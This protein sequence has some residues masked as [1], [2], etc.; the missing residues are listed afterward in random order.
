[1]SHVIESRVLES[2]TTTGA[3]DITL[4]GAVLGFRRFSAACAVGDTMPYFI[5]AIDSVGLPTGDYEYGIG[6]YSAV[7]TLTRT[8]VEGSS[9]AGAPVDFAAGS[10]NVG[11]G[12]SKS[13][14]IGRLIGV[15]VFTASDVY[16]PTRGTNSVVVEVQAGGGGSGGCV[17]TAA[18]QWAAGRP[19]A[20]GAY[21]KTRITAGFAGVTVTVGAAG[22]AG[23]AG[24][25]GGG[26][27]GVSSFGA[28]V[29]CTGGAGGG[30]SGNAQA[31]AGF[32]AGANSSVAVGGVTNGADVAIAGGAAAV[33]FALSAALVMRAAG[34]DSFLG[35]GGSGGGVGNNNFTGQVGTG[36]GSGASGPVNSNASLAA[37]AGAAG[38][39]GIVI[40]YEYA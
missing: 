25:S 31:G 37:Q 4:A 34:G 26:S 28:I 7:N 21:G 1:M 17:A 9:N 30:G 10:K 36:Y 3:G 13:Q 27:G 15:R 2:S 24:D 19:G 16:T 8:T 6:T 12:L 35:K 33:P 5:E 22:A 11:I 38:R 40:V 23:A 20:G 32:G 18:G 14:V 29:S 39:P